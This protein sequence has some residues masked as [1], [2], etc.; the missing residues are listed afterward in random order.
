[1][2]IFVA[3]IRRLID[4]LLI[5][6]RRLT[7]LLQYKLWHLVLPFLDSPPQKKKKEEKRQERS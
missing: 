5:I 6:I 7:Q 4:F 2:N 3:D 1:M